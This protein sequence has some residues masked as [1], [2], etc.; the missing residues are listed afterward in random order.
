M[1]I[2]SLLSLL[3]CI[4]YLLLGLQ[5][6]QADRKSRL[7]RLFL[8]FTVSL[9]IWSFGFIF[10]YHYFNQ[11][12]AQFWF[13]NKF[14]AFGW[15]VYCGIALHL[16]LELTHKERFLRNKLAYVLIYGP[17][18]VVLAAELAFFGPTFHPPYAN[19]I[20]V[21]LDGLY[22]VTCIFASLVLVWWWGHK[23]PLSVERNQA[24]LI[25]SAGL[26]SFGSGFVIQTI[27][28]LLGMDKFPP[29]G[30]LMALVWAYGVRQ[31]IIKYK[32]LNLSALVSADEILAEVTDLIFL[33]N[34]ERKIIR[35]NAKTEEVLGYTIDELAEKHFQTFIADATELQA[36]FLTLFHG[37]ESAR[38]VEVY[39][40]AK[41][42]ESIP[43]LLYIKTV[44]DGVGDLAGLILIGQDLRVLKKLEYLSFHDPLTG[45]FNRVFFERE[46][47][48]LEN[49]TD[50]AVGII[51]SDIDG[52]KLINDT[53]GHAAGDKL[54]LAGGQAMERAVGSVGIAARV[55]GDEF[56]VLL[57]GTSATQMQ[58]IYRK[59]KNEAVAFN[60]K[61]VDLSLSLS[62][63][64]AYSEGVVDIRNLFKEAD[65]NMYRGKLFKSKSIHSAIIRT[66]TE[67]LQARD[68]ITEG[69]AERLQDIV[70][71][72]GKALQLPDS[73]LRDLRLFSQFHDIG[74]VGIPDRILF[75]AG[76]LTHDEQ[77]DMQRH[78]EIGYRIAVSSPELLPIA[79]WV[80]KHHEW[81]DGSGYPIG[82]KMEEIP[83][84]CRILAIADAYDSMTNDRPYRLATSE[85]DAAAELVRGAG[86]QFDPTLVQVFL[87]AF[88]NREQNT[89]DI[90]V[91]A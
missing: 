75:K 48:R 1:Q 65:D 8:A 30:Q 40:R 7:N 19:D 85:A 64:Y 89:Q 4:V 88:S 52:L 62:V 27:M 18:V 57:K 35:V 25:V 74:K 54:I 43:L 56:A 37:G 69:H 46:M 3:A 21:L 81:W 70:D 23:S 77:K 12:T 82:L 5:V 49:K 11:T 73:S 13:W 61:H 76:P 44:K 55:G 45:L 41:T 50:E 86:T 58:D 91:G 90:D 67:T 38:R 78:S 79:E 31:A 66:L 80:L 10:V 33:L 28:P 68:F 53:F 32:F 29:S 20:F 63:G 17:G 47:E 39:I 14:A 24:R 16:S 26:I 87:D 60:E 34:T 83:L 2:F 22:Y 59:I 42:G 9:A 51:L 15:S 84:A 36:T 6:Y 71:V 72:M